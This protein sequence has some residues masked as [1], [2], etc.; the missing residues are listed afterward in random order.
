MNISDIEA[1]PLILPMKQDFKISSGSVGDKSQGAP[2]VYVKVTADNGAVGWGEA[3]PS[4]RWSYETLET[5]TSTITNYLRPVLLGADATDLYTVHSLMN[6]EIKAGLGNGQPIAKA[7]VDIAMHDLIGTA[8]GKRLADMW[9]SGYKPSS[10]LSYLIS[11]SSPEEAE[12]KALF[13]KSKG[14]R[15]VDVKIGLNTS[16]DIEILDAV[17]GAA[18][19]LF[20][21]VDANQAYTLQQ[22]V[23]LAKRMEQIGVDVFEQPLKAIDLFGHAE[24]RRKTCIPIAL[25]ESI[26]TAGDLIQAIRAE[27]CDTVVIK[28]TKMGGLSG[29]KLCGDIAREAGLGLLGGGLTESRLGLT[30][31]AH[32][33]NYLQITEPVD[34]NGPIFLQ[35]DPIHA[36]PIIDEGHVIL[37]DKPGIGC[38]ISIE[39]LN[40]YRM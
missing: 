20:M 24:L 8:S 6:K 22:A 19:D 16:L 1:F 35:D 18:P 23:K 2:H 3:R 5:V 27:A 36:G 25:D 10:Q 30:A 33:F 13:A 9:F 11:T 28:I 34:L 26:W 4:H 17:K 14:Y 31:S 7:A 32:L 12:Q 38:E 29:A 40:K 37:P 21:R 39:K 15:G